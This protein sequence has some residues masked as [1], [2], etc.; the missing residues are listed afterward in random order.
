M[1][2]HHHKKFVYFTDQP[3]LAKH[4]LVSDLCIVIFISGL[5]N[6]YDRYFLL[7]VYR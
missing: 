5:L 6:V 7:I 4:V 3:T 1:T 2:T